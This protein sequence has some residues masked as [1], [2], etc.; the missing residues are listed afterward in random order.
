MR[1]LEYLSPSSIQKYKE[2]K[3]EF[4]L[5]YM[6]DTRAPRF[7]QTLP[8]SIGSS[9]DAYVKSF[10]H[11]NLFGKDNDPK[12]EFTTL[13]EA[14][15]EPHN[16]TWALDHGRE[17]FDAY[18][19]SGALADLMLELSAAVTTPKFEIEVKG[20]VNGQR[21]GITRAEGEVVF[22]GKP[23]VF[24][25]N[26]HHVHVI[27]D[28]K[29]NGWC[30]NGN[31]SPMA[32]Y[33]KI[34]PGSFQPLVQGP[35]KNCMAM[36]FKGTT[37]NVA[38]YLNDLKEDWANQLAIYSWLCGAEIGEESIVAIDQICCKNVGR[39]YPEVRVAE[40]RLRV[41]P[42]YQ[43]KLYE[44]AKQIWD[45]V[46]SNHF[47]RDVSLEDSLARCEML[48]RKAKSLSQPA[49]EE[50]AIFNKLTRGT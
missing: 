46:R 22:L 41:H 2:D 8:M 29:V 19:R 40:H 50:D 15:V 44:E 14:Q 24:Y 31:T 30:G 17:A 1:R 36:S 39:T 23:D 13:F 49:T 7:P 16:R 9:F 43:R 25:T 18:K 48:D 11:N 33:L 21:D 42:D 26:K 4:Y 3:E 20:V 27:L 35:H 47:F 45:V 10:L 28:F 38:Q 32:G 12:F 37:I 34:R 5:T 6:A